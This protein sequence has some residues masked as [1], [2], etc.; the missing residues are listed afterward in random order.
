[1]LTINKARRTPHSYTV[2]LML[3]LTRA[4]WEDGEHAWEFYYNSD[5]FT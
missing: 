1:M 4:L 2:L 5:G 3:L